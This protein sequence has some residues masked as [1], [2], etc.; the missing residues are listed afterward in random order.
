MQLHKFP[1]I[2][3][4]A[5]RTLPEAMPYLPFTLELKGRKKEVFGLLDSGSTVNVLPYNIGLELGAVWENQ[6]IPLSLK[7]NLANYEARALFVTA[8]I[9][10]FPSVDLAFAW[11][12]SEFSTLILGQTNF[13]LEFDVCF[14][15]SDQEFEMTPKI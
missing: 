12:K 9:E 7:G 11:T 10:D 5:D 13:F 14:F 4:L 6:R 1:Y 2:K 8:K 3:D 15:R